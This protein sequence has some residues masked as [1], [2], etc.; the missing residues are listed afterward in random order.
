MKID[1]PQIEWA[2]VQAGDTILAHLAHDNQT[3]IYRE[4]KVA[5]PANYMATEET[6]YLI[7]RPRPVFPE[8]Y[9]SIII[10]KKV[11]GIEFPD[12]VVLTRQ[13]GSNYSY[14]STGPMWKSLGTKISGADNHSERQIEDWVLA[15]VVPA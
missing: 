8:E 15:K 11:R 12:G 3:H 9:G 10:A 14:S 6:L 7:D 2:D 13:R 5:D 4:F 1:Y